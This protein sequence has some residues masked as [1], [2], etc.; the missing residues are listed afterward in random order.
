MLRTT[1]HR[2]A[3]GL[4]VASMAAVGCGGGTADPVATTDT[5]TGSTTATASDSSST[6]AGVEV[7]QWSDN[8][9]ITVNDDGTF[10]FESDGLPSHELPDQF[11][12][13]TTGSFTPPVT[14]DEVAAVDT[15]IAVVASPVD[16]TISTNPVYSET[17][18]LTGL[19]IIGV[20]ISGAQMFNDYEDMERAFVAVDDNFAVDGVA[21]VDS[22]NGHP[23]ALLA[24]GTGAGNYH[25]HGIPYCITDA[26][27]VAGDHSTII[28]V[29]LDGFPLYGDKDVDGSQLLSDD[30]DECSGHVG[31][32]PEY[33]EGIYHYHL[34]EDRSP[35]SIDC[36]HGEI[37][38]AADS[39][40][41]GQAGGPPAGGPPGG[42]PPGGGPGDDAGT[43]AGGDAAVMDDTDVATDDLATRS[44]VIETAGWSD[45]VGI[46]I[47]GNRATFISDGLPSH[48]YLDQ[49]LADGQD[50]KYLAGG[51]DAYNANFSFPVVP[52]VADAPSETGNGAIGVAIS[53]AVFFDPYEG[54][55]SNTVA[56]D[57]NETIDGIPFIDACGGHPLPN[58]STYHYHGIPFCITDAIDTAGEHS[59]IVG[60]LFDGFP[61]Y[62]PQD[63]G[64]QEP[65]NLD[66]CLGHTGSTPEFDADTYHYHV[67]STAN[68]ISE[69]LTGVA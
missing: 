35:Y 47:D 15:D 28:G 38:Q 69:C 16:Q 42:G 18:T 2:L 11:L 57:D 21:F 3:A 36:Y 17:T 44:A 13:P 63:V 65:T 23:L 29:L 12:V 22:C 4:V 30:L 53:G 43:A 61:I 58:A 64:G 60:F 48:E 67:T 39:G 49:Y 33:T 55:G 34:T 20:T 7:A 10:R 5:T 32:T 26:V 8:V 51:V 62:G 14:E 24:D 25:Y 1:R 52:T 31:V 68:Y 27:D 50:G 54:N 37:E 59:A 41:G 46:T 66:A 56:N 6:L 19:G 40:P 45:N 9:T